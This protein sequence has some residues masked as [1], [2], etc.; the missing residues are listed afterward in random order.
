MNGGIEKVAADG[1][2]IRHAP[3]MPRALAAYIRKKRLGDWRDPEVG[4]KVLIDLLMKYPTQSS[5]A[6]LLGVS[7][8]TMTAW[9]K[10]HDIKI[11]R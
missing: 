11:E 2:V 10:L 3:Y 5:V 8:A 6:D 4:K 1:T 7:R 9:V